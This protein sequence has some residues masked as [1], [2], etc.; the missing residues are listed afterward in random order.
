MLKYHFV[1]KVHILA[2]PERKSRKA[3]RRKI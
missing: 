3:I 2:F 1:D